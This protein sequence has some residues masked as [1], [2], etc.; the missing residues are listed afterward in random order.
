MLAYFLRP[1]INNRYCLLTIWIFV[2]KVRP[3]VAER[4]SAAMRNYNRGLYWTVVTQSNAIQFLSCNGSS[5]PERGEKSIAVGA[6]H[7]AEWSE[8]VPGGGE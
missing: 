5:S 1:N 6:A 2:E 7:G 8:A 3:G 4:Q